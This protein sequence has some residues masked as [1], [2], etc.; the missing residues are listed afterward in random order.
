[1]LSKPDKGIIKTI[2]VVN[3]DNISD[4][5]SFARTPEH[6]NFFS[7]LFSFRCQSIPVWHIEAWMKVQLVIV[8]EFIFSL[9]FLKLRFLNAP[10]LLERK[11]W[12]SP[13]L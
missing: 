1:M 2:L 6:K 8:I 10:N 3:P 7:N 9:H 12:E 11:K 5:K 13:V 4:D